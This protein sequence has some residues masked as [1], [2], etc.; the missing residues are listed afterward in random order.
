MNHDGP[1]LSHYTLSCHIPSIEHFKRKSKRR[2]SNSNDENENEDFYFDKNEFPDFDPLDCNDGFLFPRPDTTLVDEGAGLCAENVIRINN[3]LCNFYKN[4][5]SSRTR[6]Y[7][8]AISN[9]PWDTNAPFNLHHSSVKPSDCGN[10]HN[11]ICER[12]VKDG[13]CFKDPSYMQLNCLEACGFCAI[14][15]PHGNHG[16]LSHDNCKDLAGSKACSKLANEMECVLNPTYMVVNCRKTCGKCPN[17][18]MQISKSK[19]STS[20]TAVGEGGKSSANELVDLISSQDKIA[21]FYVGVLVIGLLFV[22]KIVLGGRLSP[23]GQM[24]KAT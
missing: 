4:N 8:N 15:Q 23:R 7:K 22:L 6:A 2:D 14:T 17:D 3:A 9:C 11:K 21:L 24:K 13:V 12:D 18:N 5:C 19:A 16:Q 1:I 10:Q 20:S